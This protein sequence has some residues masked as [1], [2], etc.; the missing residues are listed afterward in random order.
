M[1]MYV[2]IVWNK[3]VWGRDP[4]SSQCVIVLFLS[5]P[6]FSFRLRRA[7]GERG[8]DRQATEREILQGVE[9]NQDFYPLGGSNLT[10][11]GRQNLIVVN[12][13]SRPT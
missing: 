3:R 7:R 6:F 11:F 2:E 13:S 4:G 5:S 1:Y 9:R 8:N 10:R 12:V